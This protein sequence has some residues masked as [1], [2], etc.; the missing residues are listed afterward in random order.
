[1]GL[2]NWNDDGQHADELEDG[3]QEES[4]PQQ[5]LQER[6]LRHLGRGEVQVGSHGPSCLLPEVPSDSPLSRANF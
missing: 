3:P 1:M 4:I 5:V 6:G 2:G